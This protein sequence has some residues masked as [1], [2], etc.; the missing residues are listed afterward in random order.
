MQ[1]KLL[2]FA[3]WL[4]HYFNYFWPRD[5]HTHKHIHAHNITTTT[6]ATENIQEAASQLASNAALVKFYI[7][8]KHN[9]NKL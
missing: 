5:T 2:S 9:N 3:V 7:H 4:L 8:N 6:A 1:S